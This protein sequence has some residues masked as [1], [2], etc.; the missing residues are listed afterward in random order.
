TTGPR[1]GWSTGRAARRH[2]T[3]W[4]AEARSK[5]APPGTGATCQRVPTTSP[6]CSPMPVPPGRSGHRGP[7][8]TGRS[9]PSAAHST[10]RFAARK[11]RA[12]ARLWSATIM[13]A[14][15]VVEDGAAAD[16]APTRPRPAP[17]AGGLAIL[18]ATTAALCL[19][20]LGFYLS[21]Y[22]LHALN[23]VGW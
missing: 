12:A 10:E 18:W 7:W 3:R 20:I 6:A 23:P 15:R 17:T 2:S 5:Q 16:P 21:H 1:A 14:V 19:A 9:A 13:G 11:R 8:R 22:P 4:R